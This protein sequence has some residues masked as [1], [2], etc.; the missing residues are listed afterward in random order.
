MYCG[1]IEV[2]ARVDLLL[3]PVIEHVSPHGWQWGDHVNF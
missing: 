2:E 1:C 3:D